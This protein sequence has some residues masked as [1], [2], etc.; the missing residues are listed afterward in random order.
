[1]LG[2]VKHHAKVGRHAP[3]KITETDSQNLASVEANSSQ[4]LN[5]NFEGLTPQL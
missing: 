4:P 3:V 2:Y 1:M 5:L